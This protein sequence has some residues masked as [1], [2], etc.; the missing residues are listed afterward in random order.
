MKMRIKRESPCL[1]LRF[2][3]VSIIPTHKD[4]NSNK[5]QS[6]SSNEEEASGSRVPPLMRSCS[7]PAIYDIE[8]HPASPVFPHLLLGNGKDADNPEGVGANWVLNVTCQPP[9]TSPQPGMK[10]K[11]IPASDTPHQ[12]IKQYFQEAYDFIEEARSKGSTVLLHCHAGISRSATIAIAYAMRY[13][14][15]SLIEAYKLVKGARPII[16]PNLNFMGQLLE[17]EQSLRAAGV[18]EPLSP[19]TNATTSQSAP[20]SDNEMESDE[21]ETLQC[22]RLS[23]LTF[24][25][26]SCSSSSGLP[27]AAE[28]V[29]SSTTASSVSS[30]C[31]SS[32]VSTT[33]PSIFS[34]NN[35]TVVGPDQQC[36]QLVSLA[37]N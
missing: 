23:F 12:N 35:N 2:R 7:S 33:V 18:L 27:E 19:T 30:S 17:L 4:Y 5:R 36:P 10:Y 29:P 11:Q 8:T 3:P 1:V 21:D 6:T 13:K 22:P 34:P 24:D 32:P 31:S 20:T 9:N 15:L 25:S 26:D 37:N 16:S 28:S 14:S